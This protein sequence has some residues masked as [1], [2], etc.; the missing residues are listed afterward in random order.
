VNSS[1]DYALWI[2]PEGQIYQDL[3]MLVDD[4]SQQYSTPPFEPHIT[5][6]GRVSASDSRLMTKISQLSGLI[7]RFKVNLVSVEA[8]DEYFRCLFIKVEESKEL[9]DLRVFA[10]KIFAIKDQTP[11]AP[12]VSL[13]YGNLPAGTKKQ[14][15]TEIGSGFPAEFEVDSIY[16]VSASV[17]VDPRRWHR[18]KGFPLG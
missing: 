17:A 12:H 6:L 1:N 5:V 11:Y 4:L 16:L 18:I 13:V 9:T 14:I 8:L 3:K 7:R 10:N 15:I 2:I